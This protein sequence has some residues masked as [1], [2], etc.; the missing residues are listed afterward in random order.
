[1]RQ[2]YTEN[3]PDDTKHRRKVVCQDPL[4]GTPSSPILPIHATGRQAA[5]DHPLSQTQRPVI[6]DSGTVA[7]PG[8]PIP[9]ANRR[10]GGDSGIDGA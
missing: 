7:N 6:R 1:M 9:A 2:G 8:G 3:D 4:P 5:V 10:G